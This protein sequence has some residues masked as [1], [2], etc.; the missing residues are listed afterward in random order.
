M[1]DFSGRVQPSSVLRDELK[2]EK[3]GQLMIDV[4]DRIRERRLSKVLLDYIGEYGTKGA[5]E[6]QKALLWSIYAVEDTGIKADSK[7]GTKVQDMTW[8]ISFRKTE[9]GWQL[10]E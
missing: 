7:I 6:K 2:R 1:G 10:M 5:F 8:K 9:N 3:S 4:G